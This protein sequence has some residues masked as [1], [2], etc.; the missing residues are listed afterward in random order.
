[1][2]NVGCLRSVYSILL[3]LA[4]SATIHLLTVLLTT[5]DCTQ[6]DVV[7]FALTFQ[8][9]TTSTSHYVHI[10]RTFV[11]QCIAWTSSVY[12]MVCFDRQLNHMQLQD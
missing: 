3:L 12:V 4:K 10:Q 9:Q 1:V 2:H 11:S 8:A 6:Y 5:V 7:S